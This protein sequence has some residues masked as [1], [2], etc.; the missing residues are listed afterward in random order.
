MDDDIGN[1]YS[2]DYSS[3]VNRGNNG[4]GVDSDKVMMIVGNIMVV[5]L[6]WWR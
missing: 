3:D 6:V 4:D 1:Y 2:D 5:I